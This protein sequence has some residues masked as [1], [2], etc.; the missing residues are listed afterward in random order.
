MESTLYLPNSLFTQ[1]RKT[2]AFV[3]PTVQAETETLSEESQ[4]EWLM[5]ALTHFKAK[6]QAARG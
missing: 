5:Q 4:M 1:H 6:A 3:K 2:L